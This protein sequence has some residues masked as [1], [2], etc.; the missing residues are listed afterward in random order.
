MDFDRVTLRV[1]RADIEAALA[2]V[3]AKHNLTVTTGGIRYSP[4]LAT[5][6]VEF[7]K[8]GSGNRVEQ[9]FK[10]YAE[11]FDLSPDDLGK[12]FKF[13]GAVFTV[14]GL[15]PNSPKFPLLATRAD[16]KVFKFPVTTFVKNRIA[17]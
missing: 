14:T 2:S 4:T 17:A 1:L 9:E 11:L 10:R 12:K 3:A 7:A 8:E 6:K 5:V 15:K 13:N 16:G